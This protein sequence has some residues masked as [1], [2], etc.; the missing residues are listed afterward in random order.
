MKNLRNY[1][2]YFKLCLF[3]VFSIHKNFDLIFLKYIRPPKT[4]LFI[5]QI[6]SF[7]FKFHHNLLRPPG[8][9]SIFNKCKNTRKATFKIFV[10]YIHVSIEK[11]KNWGISGQKI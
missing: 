9:N 6:W 11:S 10:I 3:G 7:C 1:K 5:G 2:F 4:F 8:L